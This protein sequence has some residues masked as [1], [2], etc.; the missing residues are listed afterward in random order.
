VLKRLTAKLAS[1]AEPNIEPRLI[2]TDPP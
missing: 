2:G 1:G